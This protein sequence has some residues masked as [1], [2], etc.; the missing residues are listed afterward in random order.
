MSKNEGR[1]MWKAVE[2]KWASSKSVEGEDV[3]IFYIL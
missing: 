2:Y 1:R 3:R